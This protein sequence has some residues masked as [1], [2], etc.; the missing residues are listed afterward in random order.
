MSFTGG[1][2]RLAEGCF[3]F[4]KQG[5]LVPFDRKDVIPAFCHD[6]GSDCFLTENSVTGYDLAGQIDFGQKT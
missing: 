6:F 3:N 4:F 5:P 2:D 1:K